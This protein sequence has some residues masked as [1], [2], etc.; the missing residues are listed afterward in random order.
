[1]TVTDAQVRLIMKERINGKTQDQS[2]FKTLFL[3]GSE[4]AGIQADILE[5][6]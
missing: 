5:K 2:A 1:M 6:D 4:S 3:S